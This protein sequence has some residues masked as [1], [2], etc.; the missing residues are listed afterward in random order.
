MRF[1]GQGSVQIEQ[2]TIMKL[3][4]GWTIKRELEHLVE[5]RPTRPIQTAF[6]IIDYFKCEISEE[7]L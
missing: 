2:M 7:I 5:V 1:Y 6:E 4:S 3:V